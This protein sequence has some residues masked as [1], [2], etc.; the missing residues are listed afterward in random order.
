[1]SHSRISSGTA[2]IAAASVQR[3]NGQPWHTRTIPHEPLAYAKV[4]TPGTVRVGDVAAL[5]RP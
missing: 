1:M 3:V 4:V 5:T 2:A